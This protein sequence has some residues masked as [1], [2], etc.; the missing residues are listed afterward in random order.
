MK[1]KAKITKTKAVKTKTKKVAK[2]TCMRC[3]RGFQ[4]R[5][6][7]QQHSKAH[8][9]ALYEIKMLEQGHVPEET[10]F[11]SGFKGKNKIIVT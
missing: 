11:G 4:T 2:F 7:L 6:A 1:K 8:L 3:E 5:K 9:Q 10:K